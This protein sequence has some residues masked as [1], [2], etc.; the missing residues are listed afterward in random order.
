MLIIFG[1]IGAC[2]KKSMADP[3]SWLNI[4]VYIGREATDFVNYNED[5]RVQLVYKEMWI[6]I[7]PLA[8]HDIE[9]PNRSNQLQ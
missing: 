3:P 7:C 4:V 9:D 5:T 8:K 6:F 2:V 1:S